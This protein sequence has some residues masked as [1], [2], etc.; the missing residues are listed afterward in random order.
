MISQLK[1]LFTILSKQQKRRFFLLLCFMVLMSFFEIISIL[2]LIDFVNF[3]SFENFVEYDGVLEKFSNFLGLNFKLTDIQTRGFLIISLLLLSSTFVLIETYLSAKFSSITAGEIETNLFNYYLKRDYLTHINLTSDKLL[4]N[5]YELVRRTTE[6]VLTPCLVILS[7]ILFLVPLIF[8]LIIYKPQVTFIACFIFI[9]IYLIFF[10]TFKNRLHYLGKSESEAT[11]NKFGALQDGFGGIKETKLFNKFNFFIS[12]YQLIYATLTRLSVQRA[13]I[14]RTPKHLIEFFTFSLSIILVIF[15]TKNLGYGL[16]QIIFTISFF[17]ICAYKIIPAFQQVYYHLNI[18]SY[19]IA[20]LKELTPDLKEMKKVEIKSNEEEIKNSKFSNFKK[21]YLKNLN[22]NYKN[23]KLK[24][25]KDISLTVNKGEKIAIT[26]SSGAGKTTLIN[27]ISCLIEPSSGDILI[28]NEK[29][30]K[31]DFTH[32]QKLI[33]FVPQSVY[34]TKN[35]IEENIAFGENIKKIKKNKIKQL[36]KFSQLTNVVENLPEKENT[37]IG[38]RG[39]KL[40]GG[41]QQRIGIARALYNDP[42][43]LIFDEATN[44]LDVLTENEILNSI[45]NFGKD[46]T[47]FM[48]THRIDVVKTFDKIIFLNEGKLE[49]FGSFSKLIE[50]NQKFKDLVEAKNKHAKN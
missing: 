44:A 48:I 49:G 5:I 22:F 2:L 39:I 8:G 45:N 34:L 30:N 6:H 13:L 25:V 24:T 17:I 29:L 26:G 15:L 21:I 4:N 27:I 18:V 50:T 38:E 20:A 33:G 31:K 1:F 16:N 7:K 37:L 43:I 12:K 40:S 23:S 41:Q 47:I 14:S 19:H 10:K 36:I 9:G 11:Q 3:L 46:L 32:W 28:D 35:S 42:K